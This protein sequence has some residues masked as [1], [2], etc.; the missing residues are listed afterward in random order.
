MCIIALLNNNDIYLL[1]INDNSFYIYFRN[2]PSCPLRFLTE[3]IYNILLIFTF[4]QTH[5]TNIICFIHNANNN[6]TITISWTVSHADNIMQ[7]SGII[8]IPLLLEVPITSFCL[9][10]NQ[11]CNFIF[12]SPASHK[13]TS[14][15]T[16]KGHPISGTPFDIYSLFTISCS[17]F[18]CQRFHFI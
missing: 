13:S 15:I 12:Q 10:L 3:Q 17:L 7:Q 11:L 9:P 2:I 6:I 1:F 8:T 18:L 16:E 4:F 5:T 14:S